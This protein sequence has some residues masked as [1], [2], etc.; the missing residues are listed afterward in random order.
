MVEELKRVVTERFLEKYGCI[1]EF[2]R[3]LPYELAFTPDN[4]DASKYPNIRDKKDLPVLA[5]A[6]DEDVDILLTG[7]K[8]FTVLELT[9]PEVLTPQTFMEKYG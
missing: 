8:D 2:L 3:N 1:D 6:I 9:R 7:D 5:T 4:I